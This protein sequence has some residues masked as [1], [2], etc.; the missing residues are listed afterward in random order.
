MKLFFIFFASFLFITNSN[1]CDHLT[2]TN[3]GNVNLLMGKKAKFY[4]AYKQGKCVL[5]NAL[6]TF[7]IEQRKVIANLIAKTY[8]L[9][10]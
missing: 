1:A 6:K 9:E 2:Y 4:D 7:P 10:Q 8:N 3:E 5:D